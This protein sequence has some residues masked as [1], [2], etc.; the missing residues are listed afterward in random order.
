MKL[1]F[2]EK[3]RQIYDLRCENWSWDEI[4][5]KMDLS[6]RMCMRHFDRAIKVDG[7]PKLS[8]G[9]A[10]TMLVSGRPE[11]A[12]PLLEKAMD[13]LDADYKNLREY[14]KE[15]GMPASAVGAL[16]KRLKARL[17]PVVAEGQRLSAKQLIET[18]ENKMTMVLGYMD[19]LAMSQATL[20]DLSI[21]FSVLTEK[22]E[23]LAGRP[24]QIIDLTTRMEL[25]KLMPLMM[26]EAK[27]R[28]LVIDNP[29]QASFP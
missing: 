11:L 10:N 1:S 12:A 29:P 22:R 24:T 15:V 5:Q 28:G 18:I 8:R 9:R 14:C 27:R 25:T 19:D 17:A 7:L 4:G 21:S 20:K 2:K 13:P 6:D 16:I 3:R 26:Q 23:L